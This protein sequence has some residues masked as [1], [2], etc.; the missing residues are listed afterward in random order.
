MARPRY[1]RSSGPLPPP[2][3]PETR[4]VG[5]LVAETIKLYG[6]HFWRALPLGL[7]IAVADQLQ[8]RSAVLASAVLLTAAYVGAS[9]IVTGA[10]PG[11][12][13]IATAFAGGVLAYLPFALSYLV[14]GF[15][16]LGVAWLAFVGL[17]VPVAI[18]ER[19]G[20]LASFRRAFR[21]ARA[22]YVHA[23]GSLATLAILLF[24]VRLVLVVLLHGL[25]DSGARAAIF[26]GDLV[27]SP[28]VFL[29]ATLLYVDQVARLNASSEALPSAP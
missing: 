26:L 14:L 6:A 4:T 3:P 23:L 17:V 10:R 27:V 2:L 9:L 1:P 19:G 7:G 11:A 24:L 22:D 16:L 8:A 25:G 12:R 21:L 18:A 15:A 5:Q 29:G 28:L 20:L 13:A